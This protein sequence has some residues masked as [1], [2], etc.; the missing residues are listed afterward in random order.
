MSH[1]SSIRVMSHTEILV[2]V[3]S[4]RRRFAS[5]PPRPGPCCSWP[6]PGHVGRITTQR[7]RHRVAD[8]A[9]AL[10]AADAA[11]ESTNEDLRA[12]I[13]GLSFYGC[14]QLAPE[15]KDRSPLGHLASRKVAER[16]G[17]GTKSL[18]IG[19]MDSH[20][21]H[22]SRIDDMNVRN[23]GLATAEP[24]GRGNLGPRTRK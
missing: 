24:A 14:S 8:Y 10:R 6:L 19:K 18:E 1:N 9:A 23:G 2:A 4:F 17:P 13:Q 11:L 5:T 15:L 16:S 20:D 7:A 12:E 21:S 3:K 22:Q